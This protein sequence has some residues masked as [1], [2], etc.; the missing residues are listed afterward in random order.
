MCI[1]MYINQPIL[2]SAHVMSQVSSL[3]SQTLYLDRMVF[4]HWVSEWSM[5]RGATVRTKSCFINLG[6]LLEYRQK[7]YLSFRFSARMSQRKRHFWKGTW[8]QGHN[9]RHIDWSSGCHPQRS[10]M[11]LLIAHYWRHTTKNTWT[12]GCFCLKITSVSRAG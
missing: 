7:K 2:V 5:I 10:W 6:R 11:G 9:P 3:L 4:N 1:E 12:A 8:M